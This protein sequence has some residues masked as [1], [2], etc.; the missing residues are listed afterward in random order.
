MQNKKVIYATILLTLAILSIGGCDAK[1][2]NNS[3]KDNDKTIVTSC[4]QLS[5]ISISNLSLQ[6]QSAICSIMVTTLA[7]KPPVYLLRDLLRL[8]LLMRETGNNDI[9]IATARDV[10][11]IVRLRQQQNDD[12]SIQNTFATAWRIYQSTETQVTFDDLATALKDTKDANALTDFDLEKMSIAL[13]QQKRAHLQAAATVPIL[14]LENKLQTQARQNHTGSAQ[15]AQNHSRQH[16]YPA[17]KQA[18]QHTGKT[19][20]HAVKQAQGHPTMVKP[21]PHLT[22]KKIQ[23]HPIQAGQIRHQAVKK[24]QTHPIQTGQNKSRGGKLIQNHQTQARQNQRHSNHSLQV[25][26][27]AHENNRNNKTQNRNT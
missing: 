15:L 13:W 4:T 19:G 17:I 9:E 25:Y 18:Q 3:K 5:R 10:M 24:I 12:E 26:Q 11:D 7:R 8:V 6:K 23:T 1:D 20:R 22:V 2:P 21:S 14:T 16:K 27:F